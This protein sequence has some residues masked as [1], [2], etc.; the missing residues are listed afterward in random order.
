MPL[1]IPLFGITNSNHTFGW[2]RGSTKYACDWAKMKPLILDFFCCL[3]KRL[4]DVKRLEHRN[5]EN[6]I[7]LKRPKN[8]KYF[9][10]NAP[11]FFFTTIWKHT[12]HFLQSPV[13]V[14]DTRETVFHHSYICSI[15]R[16]RCEGGWVYMLYVMFCCMRVGHVQGCVCVFFTDDTK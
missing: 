12:H 11:N 14:E 1:I 6:E 5:S 10:W 7:R 3:G 2:L 8:C 9:A 13:C 15:D 4:R 16:P